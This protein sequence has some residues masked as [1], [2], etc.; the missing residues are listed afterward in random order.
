MTTYI[1]LKV[2]VASTNGMFRRVFRFRQTGGY[3]YSTPQRKQKYILFLS[4]IP[5]RHF[6]CFQKVLYGGAV[7]ACRSPTAITPSSST[8]CNISSESKNNN[9]TT[10][11][12]ASYSIAAATAAKFLCMKMINSNK[13]NSRLYLCGHKHTTTYTHTH[14]HKRANNYPY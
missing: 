8:T 5:P 10:T 6:F 2:E 11:T 1:F 13:L 9:S 3:V 12:T 4:S 14:T 7:V